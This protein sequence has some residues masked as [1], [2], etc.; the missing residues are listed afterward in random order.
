MNF[1][2]LMFI[3]NVFFLI[4]LIVC[5]IILPSQNPIDPKMPELK[6]GVDESN[7]RSITITFGCTLSL[8]IALAICMSVKCSKT[9]FVILGVIFSLLPLLVYVLVYMD[10]SSQETIFKKILPQEVL[11]LIFKVPKA[12]LM[13]AIVLCALTFVSLL[14]SS[15]KYGKVKA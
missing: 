2:K 8:V 3:A 13:I 15:R 12:V 9:K 6:Q 5:Y 1:L 10:L 14:T 11:D 7:K 4:G